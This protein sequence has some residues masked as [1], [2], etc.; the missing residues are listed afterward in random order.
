MYMQIALKLKGLT[1]KS[2]LK[3]QNLETSTEIL[4]TNRVKH[5]MHD[6]WCTAFL[7]IP[8]LQMN[9]Y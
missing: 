9:V 2:V 4:G 3:A 1:C 7:N 8:C 5:A 6:K